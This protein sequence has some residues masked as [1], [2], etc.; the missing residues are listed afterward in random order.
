LTIGQLAASSHSSISASTDL[1]ALEQARRNICERL[2][3]RRQEIEQTMLARVY[4]VADL[5]AVN[6]PEYAAGLR[7]AVTTG[8]SYGLAALEWGEER[9][10]PIPQALLMQA[11]QAARNGVGLDIV[12]RRYFAG[13]A[14]LGDFAM[15]E[16]KE[17][18]LL[19]AVTMHRFSRNHAALLDR[20]IVAVCEEYACVSEV[21]QVSAEER[22][23]ERVRGLLAGQPLNTSQLGYDFEAW[24][25]GML[26]AGPGAAEAIRGIATGLDR[27]LLL[28]SAGEGT[29]WAWLG[30]RRRLES[31]DI[32]C[33]IPS[34]LTGRTWLAVGEP[35]QGP[36][37]W[38]LS[39]QQAQAAMPIARRR[40]KRLVRYAEVA[41]LASM[42]QDDLLATSL[43]Q[44]YLTP[45]ATERDGGEVLRET[46]RAY[47]AAERNISSTAAALGV[48][49]R[50][51]ANR[52]R[53]VEAKLGQSLSA[54]ATEIE[55][56]LLLDGDDLSGESFGDHQ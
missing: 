39:H 11:R 1:S 51:V 9:V 33:L 23:A 2:Q 32:E 34:E 35:A 4:G 12:L 17:D 8:L 15:Q 14:V 40:P 24:H 25:L 54:A 36:V 47:F 43:R 10:A 38:R 56:A 52:L 21:R 46:L 6:D 3:E 13:H 16:A 29:F 50:T 19:G 37:G 31:S 30:G 18:K 44:L 20:L 28:V 41:L 7:I 55:A 48:S 53:L 42:L 27:R 22:R 5:A 49:R 26:A 45:L